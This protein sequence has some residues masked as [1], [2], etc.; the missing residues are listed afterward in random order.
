MDV[1]TR[2]PKVLASIMQEYLGKHLCSACATS[3]WIQIPRIHRGPRSKKRYLISHS[4]FDSVADILHE[5]LPPYCLQWFPAMVRLPTATTNGPS[6]PCG[7][8]EKKSI[9]NCDG[10]SICIEL[11]DIS[12]N[13]DFA[14]E[15]YKVYHL[16]ISWYGLYYINQRRE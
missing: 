12:G 13:P 15:I 16:C 9:V 7:F 8:T 4:S 6:G 11:V 14:T 2:L 10:K 3:C 1:W 5:R